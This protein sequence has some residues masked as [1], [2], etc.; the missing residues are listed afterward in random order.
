MIFKSRIQYFIY[1]PFID[2]RTTSF[3]YFVVLETSTLNN[4]FAL[5]PVFLARKSGLLNG[6][7][8]NFQLLI[9]TLSVVQRIHISPSLV[10]FHQSNLRLRTSTVFTLRCTCGSFSSNRNTSGPNMLIFEH[11][12]QYQSSLDR[13]LEL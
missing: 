4:C 6:K 5:P 7:T 10:F 8:K 9:C 13:K 1:C 11:G 3:L 12:H 2:M